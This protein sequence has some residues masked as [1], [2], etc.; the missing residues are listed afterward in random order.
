MKYTTTVYNVKIFVHTILAVLLATASMA[1]ELSDD[2]PEKGDGKMRDKIRAAR[3]AYITERIDL[4]PA[5]AEKF[6]PVHNEFSRKR[7][8]L[9]HQMKTARNNGM[10]GKELL[11]L[12]F[13]I[14]Q[15]QLDL[16]KSYSSKFENV[17]GADKLYKLREAEIDFRKLVLRQIQ[18][19]RNKKLQSRDD[20]LKHK[21]RK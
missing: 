14:K 3:V 8:A 9:H 2:Y 10:A 6:W 5:E 20:S 11:D 12:D 4:T 21:K 18:Q 13:Q 7:E 1:Q 16:E 15:Q 19:R 17:I